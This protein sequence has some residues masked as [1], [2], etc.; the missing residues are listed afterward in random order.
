MSQIRLYAVMTSFKA[1]LFNV[2]TVN[3]EVPPRVHGQVPHLLKYN[4]RLKTPSQ[5]CL[6][7]LI[8]TYEGMKVL[9]MNTIY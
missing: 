3:C 2:E 1:A 6:Y 4:T 5:E 8:H 9:T 7:R